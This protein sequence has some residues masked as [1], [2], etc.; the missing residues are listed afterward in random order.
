MSQLLPTGQEPKRQLL[1]FESFGDSREAYTDN[2]IPL[3]DSLKGA[4]LTKCKSASE[5]SAD[6]LLPMPTTLDIDLSHLLT[7]FP[8]TVEMLT[9]NPEFKIKE[10]LVEILDEAGT[11]DS[12]RLKVSLED[13][14]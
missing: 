1:H 7:P 11:A 3:T 5:F 2:F 6:I 13:N 10:L 4:Y 14:C 12:N 9:M 8:F